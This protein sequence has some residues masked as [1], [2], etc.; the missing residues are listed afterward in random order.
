M[1][2][3]NSSSEQVGELQK[4]G[5]KGQRDNKYDNVISGS[6]QLHEGSAF[7]DVE[8]NEIARPFPREVTDRLVLQFKDPAILATTFEH[9]QAVENRLAAAIV[10]REI[11]IGS[12]IF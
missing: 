5:E 2:G 6:L 1:F 7:N 9:C 10:S 12:V 11:V 4:G 3:R 8:S